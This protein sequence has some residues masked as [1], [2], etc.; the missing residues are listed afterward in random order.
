MVFSRVYV[1]LCPKLR[2]KRKNTHTQLHTKKKQ[3]NDIHFLPLL[4]LLRGLLS[5]E[6]TAATAVSVFFFAKAVGVKRPHS[7]A[8]LASGG[9]ESSSASVGRMVRRTKRE[10]E[11][12]GE[13]GGEGEEEE[14]GEEDIDCCSGATAV[15]SSSSSSAC[16]ISFFS[17]CRCC[18]RVLAVEEGE[19]EGEE[20]AEGEGEAVRVCSVNTVVSQEAFS[21]SGKVEPNSRLCSAFASRSPFFTACLS[22]NVASEVACGSVP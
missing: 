17:S 13:E 10:V 5:L 11:A 9:M 14:G 20:T 19:E 18:G 22:Q 1:P 3:H 4:L 21:G 8:F 7:V 16:C 2:E 6:A 12:E 15:N